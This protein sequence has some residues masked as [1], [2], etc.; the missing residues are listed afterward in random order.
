MYDGTSRFACVGR[1]DPAA[2]GH[3]L[4][5]QVLALAKWRT[6]ALT[7]TLFGGGL[8]EA[9]LSRLADHLGLGEK[10]VFAD[11]V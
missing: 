9:V 6:R 3:N 4:L 2:K 10:I 11:H 1:L 8:Y 5:F 7:V